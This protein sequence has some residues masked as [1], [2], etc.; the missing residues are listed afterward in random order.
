[1][2]LRQ[3]VAGSPLRTLCLLIAGKPADVFSSDATH[4]VGLPGA[5]NNSQQSAQVMYQDII[6]LLLAVVLLH[7]TIVFYEF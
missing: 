5:A 1:M 4:Q 6:C 7:I 2:A 3:L